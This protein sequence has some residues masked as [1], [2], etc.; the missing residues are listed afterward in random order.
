MGRQINFFADCGDLETIASW[1][2][3]LNVT[4]IASNLQSAAG[5]PRFVDVR[6][7]VDP[8]GKRF[9]LV[10]RS[11]DVAR[12]IWRRN[13]SGDFGVAWSESPVVEYTLPRWDYGGLQAGRFYLADWRGGATDRTAAERLFR[14]L[15]TRVRKWTRVDKKLGRRVG[16]LTEQA[17]RLG[18]FELKSGVIIYEVPPK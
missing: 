11:E 10:A 5:G 8:S 6:T 4:V 12:V 15:S 7:L 13:V 2:Q 17:V 16:P 1:L 3:Q 18:A 9:V 14:Q